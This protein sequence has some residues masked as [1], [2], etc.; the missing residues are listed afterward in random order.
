MRIS[1]SSINQSVT[2]A[3]SGNYQKYIEIINK[4]ASNKN[5]PTAMLIN[6]INNID[7]NIELVWIAKTDKSGSAT[8]IKKPNKKTTKNKIHIFPCLVKPL[9]TI[10]PIGII[11][12][13]AP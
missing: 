1:T 2:N 9:P 7:G 6:T 4:I 13:S 5:I 3:T 12:W 11:A 10:L 8:V